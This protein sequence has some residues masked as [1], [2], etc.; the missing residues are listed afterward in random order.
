MKLARLRGGSQPRGR[1]CG[2]RIR[3]AAAEP[4]E[5]SPPAPA[6][7]VSQRSH[8][9]VGRLSFQRNASRYPAQGRGGTS[10]STPGAGRGGL[11]A[12][13]AVRGEAWGP[14]SAAVQAA[15]GGLRPAAA[16]GVFDTAPGQP[17]AF[18]S[19][20]KVRLAAGEP[21][22]PRSPARPPHCFAGTVPGESRWGVRASEWGRQRLRGRGARGSERLRRRL[23]SEKRGHGPGVPR[24]GPV[25]SRG[26]A[27]VACSRWV[28][29][30]E[31]G[32]WGRS[33]EQV[34]WG[35]SFSCGDET[36][37]AISV[38]R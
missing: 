24:P 38:G 17:N 5:G 11:S 35:S 10:S 6:G 4:R 13:A 29:E 9:A 1:S 30:E 32:G 3:A 25:P 19:T 12:G 26:A 2:S 18:P 22:P 14:A 27:V 33:E 21:S 31:Q 23:G 7:Q 20:G 37:R 8:G 28:V 16:A 15:G 34:G 36:S